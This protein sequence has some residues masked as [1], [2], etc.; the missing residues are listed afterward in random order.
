MPR[1]KQTP[2]KNGGG[3]SAKVVAAVSVKN[4]RVR[5]SAKTDSKIANEPPEKKKRR[6]RPGTGA[7]ME[8]RRL[9][10]KDT[11]I[12][13]KAPFRRLVTSV[14]RDCQVFGANDMRIQRSAVKM[15]RESASKYLHHIFVMG[16]TLCVK[17]CRQKLNLKDFVVATNIISGEYAQCME[18]RDACERLLAPVY[19]R[20]LRA[21]PVAEAQNTATVS[22][23]AKSGV[24]P[25][26]VKKSKA[27]R[28][29]GEDTEAQKNNDAAAP[30]S[31]VNPVK[32]DTMDTEETGSEEE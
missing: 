28:V 30:D 31:T 29:K 11:R 2:Y 12:I 9:Q 3:K 25:K 27:N 24:A 5:D 10:K 7:L 21:L 1:I 15:L 14:M 16:N 6:K 26:T 32:E 8:M 18:M 4:A 22:K 19:D 13:A 23:P 20:P 17:E